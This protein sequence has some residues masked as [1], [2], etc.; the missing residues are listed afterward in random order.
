A[1]KLVIG[2][3]T[4]DATLESTIAAVKA[5]EDAVTKMPGVAAVAGQL[6]KN[7]AFVAYVPLDEIVT[8][9]GTYA[10][11]LGMPIQIQL[12][13]DL[14]PIGITTASEGSCIRVDSYTP[15]DLVK[16]LVAQAMQIYMQRM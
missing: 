12:P 3:C 11:A 6:P 1:D 16:A 10:G 7:R 8:T 14:P 15:T 4:P 9:V 13:P 5:K 2:Y